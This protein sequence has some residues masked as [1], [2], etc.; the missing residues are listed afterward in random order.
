MTTTW[1]VNFRSGD[2]LLLPLALLL[3]LVAFAPAAPELLVPE[4]LPPLLL[5]PLLLL[6]F[7]LLVRLAVAAI[8][9]LGG[10]WPCCCCCPVLFVLL[11]TV[12]PAL[13]V[14]IRSTS[15]AELLL[16]LLP[17]LPLL[18]LFLSLT[19]VGFDVT[20]L[21]P[22]PLSTGLLLTPLVLPLLPLAPP[23]DALVTLLLPL[24]LLLL[25]L[26]FP[27]LLDCSMRLLRDG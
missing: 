11:S 26:L 13:P 22:M 23:A 7:T 3:V 19:C 16:P 1:A 25:L 5:L 10:C 17:P 9:P 18:L 24:L 8:V 15:P 14:G 2:A 12:S 20:L 6:P 4:V 21:L 27:A